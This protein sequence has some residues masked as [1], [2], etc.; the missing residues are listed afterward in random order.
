MLVG[1]R[2]AA[3]IFFNVA[4]RHVFISDDGALGFVGFKKVLSFKI[5]KT[6]AFKQIAFEVGKLFFKFPVSLS[7][8]VSC[9]Y[10]A[11]VIVKAAEYRCCGCADRAFDAQVVAFE[12]GQKLLAVIDFCEHAACINCFVKIERCVDGGKILF[13][14]VN[15][16][17]R[18]GIAE[19]VFIAIMINNFIWIFE[20]KITLADTFFQEFRNLGNA[21]AKPETEQENRFSRNVGLLEPVF[22]G[23]VVG[24]LT[25]LVNGAVNLLFGA[26][27][28]VWTKLGVLICMTSSRQNEYFADK[29][30]YDIGYGTRLKEALIA[31]EGEDIPK[32]KGLWATLNSSHPETIKRIEKLDSYTAD[33]RSGCQRVSV[34]YDAP[35]EYI[36]EEDF[37]NGGYEHTR[38]YGKAKQSYDDG[39]TVLLLRGFSGM[40]QGLSQAEAAPKKSEPV[41]FNPEPPVY[42]AP[43]QQAYVAPQPQVK[44]NPPQGYTSV[45]FGY[46]SNEPVNPAPQ[47]QYTGGYQAPQAP[48][49]GGIPGLAFHKF[50]LYVSLPLTV[51]MGIV[52]LLSYSQVLSMYG[53]NPFRAATVVICVAQIILAICSITE[54]IK[55]DKRALGSLLTVSGLGMLLQ[56]V[57]AGDNMMAYELAGL[58]TEGAVAGTVIS[59]IMMGAM[60]F[61]LYFYYSKRKTI[62]FDN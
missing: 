5:K 24:F 3:K 29:F 33:A 17:R 48:V 19:A 2:A 23:C 41:R 7:L 61:A 20:V 37:M 4:F 16:L 51:I 26:A 40:P 35:T 54:F 59:V 27:M 11:A 62:L 39:E 6:L 42:K 36:R 53:I 25:S 12:Q 9:D 1:W 45:G 47:P 60:F 18:F 50:M 22:G 32:A 38:I 30:A 44:A 34:D 49:S 28:W 46:V 58:G 14:C 55:R 57:L 10:F 8:L 52:A 56:L 31:L 43:E 13:V 15:Q 21:H